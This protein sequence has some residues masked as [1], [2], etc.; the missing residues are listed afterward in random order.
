L[1]L[2]PDAYTDSY[3]RLAELGALKG[4][5]PLHCAVFAGQEGVVSALL[6]HGAEIEARDDSGR[7]PL[8]LA[9]F[10]E[11]TVAAAAQVLARGAVVDVKDNSGATPLQLAMKKGRKAPIELFLA[12][13]GRASGKEKAEARDLSVGHKVLPVRTTPLPTERE[14]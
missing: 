4:L 6:T 14:W 8:H 9:S 3:N 2:L 13:E 1:R 7:T 12:Y 11:S 5:T 10:W